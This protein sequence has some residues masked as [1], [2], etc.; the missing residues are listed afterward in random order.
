MFAPDR[1]R[2]A[3]APPLSPRVGGDCPSLPARANQKDR[4]ERKGTTVSDEYSHSGTDELDEIAETA[5]AAAETDTAAD[6]ETDTDE[7]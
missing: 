1:P 3:L 6:D 5:D 2:V 7:S 4:N